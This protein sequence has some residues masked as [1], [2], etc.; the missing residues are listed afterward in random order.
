MGTFFFIIFVLIAAPFLFWVVVGIIFYPIKF[1]HLAITEHKFYMFE[2]DDP[3]GLK[4]GAMLWHMAV[5]GGLLILIIA[6]SRAI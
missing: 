6:A 4:M 2:D 3:F 5:V 1:I